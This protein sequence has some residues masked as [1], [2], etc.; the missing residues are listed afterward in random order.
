MSISL[1]PFG[2][3]Y[4]GLG[5]ITL[6]ESFYGIICDLRLKLLFTAYLQACTRCTRRTWLRK[7]HML[8]TRNNTFL[9][10]QLGL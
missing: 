3:S 8:Q 6:S 4:L 7:L 9:R 10:L 2:L 5:W 1:L